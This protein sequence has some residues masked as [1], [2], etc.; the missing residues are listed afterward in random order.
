MLSSAANVLILEL[1]REDYIY[2][3][4]YA[5]FCLFCFLFCVFLIGKCLDRIPLDDT[6]K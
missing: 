3:Y 5:V 2:I 6:K 1:Y 4:I